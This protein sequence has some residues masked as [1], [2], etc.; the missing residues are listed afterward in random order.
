MAEQPPPK[1][2]ATTQGS[3]AKAVAEGPLAGVSVVVTRAR[4]QAAA[5]GEALAELGA[6]T[7]A[8]PVI[9]IVDPEDGG[10]M[11]RQHLAALD[12]HDWLVITSPNGATKVGE[13]LQS[14]PLA[15]GVNVAVIGPGTRARAQELGIGVDL[16]PEKSIAE[17][18]LASFP[19]PTH[20]GA[21]VVLARAAKARTVLP[22]VLAERGW[23]VHDVAAYQTVAVP[24]SDAAVEACRQSDMVAFTSSSTVS[25]L[26]AAVGSANFPPL[27]ACIGPATAATA[28]H[29]GVGVD[30]IADPHTIDG[31]VK[32]IVNY[33]AQAGSAQHG[34]TRHSVEPRQGC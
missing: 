20:R 27:V 28:R 18:L 14:A 2:L 19:E 30:V 31:L 17:G 24:V 8:V 29:L 9:Q 21:T 5:L 26:H 34:K 22:D 16:T 12:R 32:A 3:A 4:E 23:L 33:H 11:L 7:V 13:A 1:P 15:Q 10:A 25:H 6:T